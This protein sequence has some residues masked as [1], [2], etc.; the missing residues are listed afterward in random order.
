MPKRALLLAVSA[1]LLAACS[2]GSSPAPSGVTPAQLFDHPPA[3]PGYAWSFD[4]RTVD[5]PVAA[6]AA[7]PAHCAL[8][9]V[10]ML[11][12][13]WP[14]GTASRSAAHS[15]QFIRDPKGAVPA[16]NLRTTLDLH[17]HLP[18][19]AQPTGLTYRGVQIDTSPSD[20]SAVW[21]VGGGSVERWPRSDPMTLCE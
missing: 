3:W 6:T 16:A 21:V 20:G 9:S 1:L 17:A 14:A 15:R 5:W 8:Q 4:G 13:G 2:N 12:M 19:D 10:T 7:G 11:T 18:A